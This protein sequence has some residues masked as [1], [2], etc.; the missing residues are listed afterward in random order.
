M[1]LTARNRNIISGLIALVLVT[2]VVVIGVESSFGVFDDVYTL[3]ASF[4]AAGQG[5]QRNSDVKIRG[6][7]VGRVEYVKL[8]GGRALVVMDIDHGE[9][10]PTSTQAV[11]RPKTLFGEKFVDLVP[12]DGE[13]NGPYYPTNSTAQIPDDHTTGGFELERVLTDAYP[14]LKDIN[15]AELGNVISTLAYGA[16]GLGPDVNRTIASSASV[17]GVFAAHDA[18]TQQFLVDLAKLSTELGNRSDD[19]VGLAHSLDQALPPVNDR[20]AELNQLLVQTGRLS[21][22]AADLLEAN[23]AFVNSAIGPGDAVVQLLYDHRGDVI[24]LVAGLRQYL[25]GLASVIRIPVG[26]GTYM[27][28]V[29]GLLGGTVCSIIPCSALSAATPANPATA[30]AAGTPAPAAAGGGAASPAGPAPGS[31]PL[32]ALLSFLGGLGKK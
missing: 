11:V 7:N 6:V 30:T 24:P 12:G 32:Q 2:S 31:T 27:A 21:T 28:A 3:R 10:V 5:L 15:P 29:K 14:L 9:K 19:L 16:N 22:D 4:D 26:D 1:Q 25:Q 18:D 8:Q 17:A 23:T 20:A 13:V